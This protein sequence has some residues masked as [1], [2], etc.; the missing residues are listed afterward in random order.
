MRWNYPLEQLSAQVTKRMP[1]GNCGFGETV[2]ETSSLY[3]NVTAPLSQVLLL[4]RLHFWVS[5]AECK[6]YLSNK[7]GSIILVGIKI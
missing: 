4:H 1:L 5:Y 3:R 7:A 2:E 6:E